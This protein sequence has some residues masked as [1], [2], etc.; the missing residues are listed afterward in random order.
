MAPEHA[1]KLGVEPLGTTLHCTLWMPLVASPA[2][3]VHVCVLSGPKVW[4]FGPLVT[5]S[6]GAVLSMTTV[7][8]IAVLLL[9]A[10]TA[11]AWIVAEPSEIEAV[12]NEA[13]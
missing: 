5:L 8:E 7:E 2:E 1:P 3:K 10:S 4:P 13:E 12:L 11:V 6:E 9:A